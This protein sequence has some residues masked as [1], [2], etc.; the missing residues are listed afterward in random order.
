MVRIYYVD[1]EDN[2]VA[3]VKE[4]KILDNGKFEEPWPSGFFDKGY[5]LSRELAKAGIRD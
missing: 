1:K 5:I 4:M 3:T 2:G